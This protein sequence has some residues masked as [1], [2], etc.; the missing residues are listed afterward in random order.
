MSS[1]ENKKLILVF[2]MLF[3][4]CNS[5]SYLQFCKNCEVTTGTNT[6]PTSRKRGFDSFLGL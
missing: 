6:N 1:E 2:Q 5:Q 4:T 3:N